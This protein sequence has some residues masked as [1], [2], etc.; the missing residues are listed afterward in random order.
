MRFSPLF[1]S[2]RCLAF[3]F[4]GCLAVATSG[5][6]NLDDLIEKIRVPD[7]SGT[8]GNAGGAPGAGGKSG[9]TPIDPSGPACASTESCPAGTVCT[10]EKG[11]CNSPPG[12]DGSPDKACP[13]VCYGTCEKANSGGVPC[14]RTTC[15][16]G[17]VCCNASCGICTEPDGACTQ[18][19]C[20]DPKTPPPAECK[21]DAD[22]RTFSDYCTGCDCR[23]L[24]SNESDPV[25]TGPGVR[26]FADPCGGKTAVCQN[27]Q[28][29]LGSGT[30][31]PTCEKRTDGSSSSCKSPETWK[32]YAAAD[33]SARGQT[34]SE[35]YVREDCGNGSTRYV[36]YVCC[37]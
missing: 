27:G 17:K 5:C 28:C 19:A 23:A 3:A 15:A 36:D 6:D 26:C 12:C 8:G 20:E 9:G 14:G 34:L 33:C 7:G 32:T 2:P 37:K 31:A 21:S 1:V 13:A 35:I 30:A 29:V 18:Q 25:C 24:A 16:A 11:V 4:I 22:C 10:T